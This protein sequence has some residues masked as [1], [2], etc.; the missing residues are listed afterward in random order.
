MPD[1]T[2]PSYTTGI[3]TYAS[4]PAAS[5]FPTNGPAYTV[6]YTSDVGPVF[7]D[8]LSWTPFGLVVPN[9]Y[10]ADHTLDLTDMRGVTMNSASANALTVPP[11]STVAFKV[12]TIIPVE[13]YGAGITTLTAGAG[14]TIRSRGAVLTLAGQ[15]AAA[16][17]RKVST[18]EW[19][20]VGDLA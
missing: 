10:T 6:A 9:V 13:Q 17:L 3:Y 12:G 4:L 20:A 2:R 7:S 18:N 1:M 15:Y 16:N 5:T 14:V 19:L 11:N 8:G